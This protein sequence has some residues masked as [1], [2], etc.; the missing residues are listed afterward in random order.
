MRAAGKQFVPLAKAGPAN[1]DFTLDAIEQVEAQLKFATGERS[2]QLQRTLINL[3]A[4]W[5]EE[6]V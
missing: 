2:Q 4:Q 5:E 3:I 1:F 6:N